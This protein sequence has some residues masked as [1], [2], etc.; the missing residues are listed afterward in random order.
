M[1]DKVP[2]HDLDVSTMRYATAREALAGALPLP[3]GFRILQLSDHADERGVFRELFRDAWTD[4]APVQWNLVRSKPNVLRGVHAHPDHFDHLTMASGAMVL[5]L[6][7]VRPDSPT[8]G[9]SA[10]IRLEADDPHLVEIPPGVGHGFYFP[11]A[12]AHI[13][14][15]SRAFAGHDPFACRWDDPELG[16]DWPCDAPILSDRD[17]AAGSYRELVA[18]LRTPD[19]A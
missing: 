2:L 10:M 15:V 7:D 16:L 11:A 3:S 4:T 17:R 13:Y 19:A 14:G 8:F 9:L 18:R 5:G 1:A 6:H 12:A